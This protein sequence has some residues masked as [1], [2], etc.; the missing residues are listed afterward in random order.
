MLL[1]IRQGRVKCPD[2]RDS[3]DNCEKYKG[4]KIAGEHNLVKCDYYKEG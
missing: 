1:H 4:I 3:C 2:G